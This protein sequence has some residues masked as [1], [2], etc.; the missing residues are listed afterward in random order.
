MTASTPGTDE[1]LFVLA[2]GRYA[3]HESLGEGG[4]ASVHRC[5]D[6]QLAASRAI[7]LRRVRESDQGEAMVR[8]LSDEARVMARLKHRHVLPV[9]DVGYD[10]GWQYVVMALATGSLQDRL[11]SE[12]PLPPRHAVDVVLDVLDALAVAHA[13]GIV[14]RDIKPH[15]IL[16]APNG[17]IMVGDWGIARVEDRDETLTKTGMAMGSLSFMAPEQRLDAH[18][19]GAAADVYATGATLYNL[20]TGA[21]PVDLFHAGPSSPRWDDVPAL[22]RPLL[23]SACAH[24]PERRPSVPAFAASLRALRSALPSEALS[25]ESEATDGATLGVDAPVET[26]TEAATRPRWVIGTL[27]ATATVA[28]VLFVGWQAWTMSQTVASPQVRLVETAAPAPSPA[29]ASEALADPGSAEPEAPVSGTAGSPEAPSPPARTRAPSSPSAPLADGPET[30]SPREEPSAAP[31]A[32]TLPIHG[33]WQGSLDGT[34][35]RLELTGPHDVLVGRVTVR[36]PDGTSTAP[37]RGHFDPSTSTLV[38][39]VEGRGLAGGT[40]TLTVAT[41]R[42]RGTLA[43]LDARDMTAVSLRRVSSP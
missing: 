38:L 10:K 26:P 22:L 32:A 23:Q 41:D 12:G 9:Y 19:V 43:R 13:E 30:S 40:W 17:T 8:R 31:L 2:N 36:G 16:V 7:K 1:P 24:E 27:A 6:R 3:I 34:L 28:V 11:L 33:P 18:D 14:H 37:A 15:N 21:T 25:Y 35:T 39:D 42:I 29:A 5:A 20:I 4:T